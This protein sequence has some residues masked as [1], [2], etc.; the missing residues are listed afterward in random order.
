LHF[1]PNGGLV[2]NDKISGDG[3]KPTQFSMKSVKEHG[4]LRASVV[5]ELPDYLDGLGLMAEVFATNADN[6]A[7][8]TSAE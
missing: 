4:G 8:Y 1:D 6:S 7:K 3:W 2:L 5:D